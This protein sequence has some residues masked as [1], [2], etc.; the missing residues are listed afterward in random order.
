MGDRGRE[1]ASRRERERV[2]TQGKWVTGDSS[3]CTRPLNIKGDTKQGQD[4]RPHWG[5]TVPA[6]PRRRPSSRP[7]RGVPADHRAGRQLSEPG[8]AAT[9]PQIQ[10]P[11]FTCW[12]EA[13]S[14]STHLAG[15]APGSPCVMQGGQRRPPPGALRTVR[16]R[17]LSP[18]S[19]TVRVAR[20]HRRLGRG[21]NR[22]VSDEEEGEVLT[23]GRASEGLLEEAAVK[24]A[25]N[26]GTWDSVWTLSR[27]RAAAPP[28]PRGPRGGTSSLTL[29]PSPEVSP[30]AGRRAFPTAHHAPRN[31]R[32]F[33]G[34][35]HSPDGKQSKPRNPGGTQRAW[36]G[37][38][39]S[40]PSWGQ[41]QA[42]ATVLRRRP[43]PR[44]STGQRGPHAAPTQ[45]SPPRGDAR[46][47]G[48]SERRQGGR[49]RARES[50]PQDKC[51]WARP[52]LPRATVAGRS[53]QILGGFQTKL[54]V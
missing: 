30:T 50:I 45:S 13:G 5:A 26:P 40:E 53:H 39:R 12:G 49:G 54:E 20:G 36:L 37:G 14:R 35:G 34:T 31:A 19:A 1:R 8:P 22:G 41:P 27:R 4:P 3:A 15:W 52:L 23:P 24:D 32:V 2:L 42:S 10:I 48:G 25:K 11:P 21:A 29:I 46:G 18:A 43:R 51:R 7:R 16:L 47:H 44:P 17:A 6:P 33:T 28:S 38:T 9:G